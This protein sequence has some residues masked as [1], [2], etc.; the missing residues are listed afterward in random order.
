MLTYIVSPLAGLGGDLNRII[1]S[2]A[3][4]QLVLN[5]RL[6]SIVVRSRFKFRCIHLWADLMRDRRHDYVCF[7]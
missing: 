4:V 3:R 2:A 1:V 5:M 6:L 7:L